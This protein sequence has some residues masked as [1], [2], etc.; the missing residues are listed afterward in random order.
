M[1]IQ[2][3]SIELPHGI[4]LS[5]RISGPTD[6]PVLVFLHGFPQAAFVWDELL[7]HFARQGFRCVAP[8]MRGYPGSSA[9]TDPKAYKAPLVAQDIVAL[10]ALCSPSHPIEALIAHDWGGAIAWNIAAMQGA[11]RLKRLIAINS[12]HP[13]T[14]LRALQT[15]A[16]QQAASAYMRF[17]SRDDAAALLTENGFA[18]LWPFLHGADG[19]VPGWL[20]PEL[21]EAH[22]QSWAQGL[23]GP[24]AYYQQSPLKPP[25]DADDPVLALTLPDAITQVGVPTDVIWGDGDRALLPVLLDDL[26]AHVDDLRIHHV[27]DA[28]H[29]VIHEQPDVVSRLIAQSLQRN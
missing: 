1:T 12:P 22:A 5:C 14:F 10:M 27:A 23:K 25:L 15:D 8:N 18:R 17:L 16:H 21:Q 24:C 3:Q 9:P 19:S 2:I 20:T 29:W 4:T 28:T 13:A 26:H 6:G 7:T 11:T